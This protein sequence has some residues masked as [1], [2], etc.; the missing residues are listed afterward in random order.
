MESVA[1]IDSAVA[2]EHGDR[3]RNEP[4]LPIPITVNNRPYKAPKTPMTGAEIKALAG[5]P[6]DF[7]LYKVVHGRNEGPIP[8]EQPVDLKPGDRFNALRGEEPA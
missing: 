3:D 4:H 1:S 6:A 7:S 2:V 8:N 5:V